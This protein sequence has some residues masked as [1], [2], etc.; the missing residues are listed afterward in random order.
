[1]ALAPAVP[2]VQPASATRQASK[3]MPVTKPRRAITR[4]LVLLLIAFVANLVVIAII[5]NRGEP[6]TALP[7]QAPAVSAAP[8]APASAPV[9]PSS[10]GEGKFVVGT[11][12][13][14]GT[15]R[16]AGKAGHFDCY[17]ERLKDASGTGE[18]IIANNLAPGP[19]T[20]TIAKSDGAFQTRW[21]RPWTRVN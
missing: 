11:D 20:V 15:Y 7:V 8:P 12:I 17:W 9:L 13:A 4:A 14:P 18:S 16:T 3:D 1:M 19:A 2:Q 10:F 6:A 21:C 5:V